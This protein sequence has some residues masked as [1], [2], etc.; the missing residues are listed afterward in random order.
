MAGTLHPPVSRALPITYPDIADQP[1][2]VQD[3]VR[4]AYD[5]IYALRGQLATVVAAHNQ[6]K[7][8]VDQATTLGQANQQQINL[9]TALTAT[10]G[11]SASPSSTTSIVVPD[12]TVTSASPAAL[13]SISFT[14]PSGGPAYAADF[15]YF[16]YL[17]Y[18]SFTNSDATAVWVQGSVADS[19]G[20][21][22]YAGCQT[23]QSN[24]ASG[25][26]TSANC[27]DTST[28]TYPAGTAVTFTLY[29][30]T[31]SSSVDVVSAPIAGAGPNCTF[32]VGIFPAV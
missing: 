9:V 11:P 12:S 29:A 31:S 1:K 6:L 2:N 18:N 28:G 23:G 14:I 24:A 15:F 16:L 19:F 5:N 26:R 32:R 22:V 20:Q 30:Q 13:A 10:T 4:R 27:T 3:A 25:A 7:T 17:F 8:S 21:T